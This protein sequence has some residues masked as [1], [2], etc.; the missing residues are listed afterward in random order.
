MSDTLLLNDSTHF[1][2]HSIW[3][4][5]ALGF[6]AYYI[7]VM[8]HEIVGHGTVM[9]LIG[10]RHFILTSTSIDSGDLNWDSAAYKISWADRLVFMAGAFANVILGAL[11]YPLFR[12]LSSRGASLML[13][14]FLWLLSAVNV[15]IGFLAVAY[16]GWFGMTD[17]ADTIAGLPH[18]ALLRVLEAV[19]GTSLCI[20]AVR[21][22]AASFAEFPENLWLLSLVPYVSASLIFCV[23]GLR[24]PDGG[25]LMVVSV[26]PAALIGQS[27]L[28]FIAPVARRLRAQAPLRKAIATSPSA[29]VIALAF[30]VVILLTAPGVRFT[31][32]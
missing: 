15:F 23:A 3:T 30:V 31:L 13:R 26:I 22:F 12:F 7:T 25:K 9:Y 16:S 6:L 14:Y 27:I 21:F 2:R 20:G 17:W 18:H 28:V 8:W 5:A 24:I 32:P 11:T 29:I 1:H 10:A 4:L 19:I